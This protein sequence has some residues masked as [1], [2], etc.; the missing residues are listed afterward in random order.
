MSVMRE[1]G[2]AVVDRFEDSGTLVIEGIGQYAVFQACQRY[3]S[4]GRGAGL[5]IYALIQGHGQNLGRAEL[6]GQLYPEND[7]S[8]DAE[9]RKSMLVVQEDMVD[10][11]LE[12]LGGATP[13][14]RGEFAVPAERLY[15]GL[16]GSV[17]GFAIEACATYGTHGDR[18]QLVIVDA[19]GGLAMG[20]LPIQEMAAGPAP[21]LVGGEYRP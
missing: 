2:P 10:A 9:V 18:A 13:R 12:T 16:S 20:M 1:T 17:A 3:P 11:T 5:Y 15:Q 14:E 7:G 8:L 6:T 4:V 21:Q 19:T